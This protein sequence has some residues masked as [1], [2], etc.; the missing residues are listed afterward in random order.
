M[1]DIPR[2]KSNLSRM[3]DAGA[4]ESDI[5]EYL[6]TEGY[7]SAAE[8]TAASADKGSVPWR[9]AK[10]AVHDVG[11]IATGLY[12]AVSDPVGTAKGIYKLGSGLGSKMENY[13]NTFD[14][15]T[16]ALPPE[17]TTER[18]TRDKREEL[19]TALINEKAEAY[20]SWD[21]AM[22]T[23]IDR[24]L[25]TMLDI[26]SVINPLGAGVTRVSP[27]ANAGTIAKKTRDAAGFVTAGGA[28][29]LSGRNPMT[30]VESYKAGARGGEPYATLV[31]NR[32]QSIPQDTV[33]ADMKT[34]RDTV[35]DIRNAEY[36][37]GIKGT[38]EDGRPID[39]SPI[40]T[41]AD[42]LIPSLYGPGGMP[43][44]YNP[45][46]R[47]KASDTAI[48]AAKQVQEE[49]G[50]YGGPRLGPDGSLVGLNLETPMQL[51]ALKQRLQGIAGEHVMNPEASR[52]PTAAADKVR[53]TIIAQSPS[54]EKVMD[55][56]GGTS[57][58][59]TDI[60]A[61]LGLGNRTSVDTALRKAGAV[62][63]RDAS[64]GTRTQNAK[65]LAAMGPAGERIMPA[66]AGQATNQILPDNF[67]KLAATMLLGG[68]AYA[69]NPW[70]LALAP[71][72]SPLVSGA[73]AGY[74]GRAVGGAR[75]AGD[76]VGLTGQR[77]TIA[78]DAITQAG[79]VKA[80]E[81]Y[82]EKR[83]GGR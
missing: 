13:H 50:R 1:A 12:N 64:S 43:D 28:G 23:A 83:A 52:I 11:E 47:P 32:T 14:R 68:G 5:D 45:K 65:E 36:Q 4:P 21:K 80:L 15:I 72:A 2:I 33:I 16:G 82:N 42:E 59:L 48:N 27:L 34:A 53:Q 58:L 19:A 24:P 81:D 17:T 31:G 78:A 26:S 18:A 40:I 10:G 3:I 66:L 55:A 61:S 7:K 70:L 35:K 9:I 71:F 76:A 8:W 54:Y 77:A 75:K 37:A 60:D 56:Y 30:Y 22:N 49:I 29:L 39:V 69:T 57:N 41:H 74:Y 51:D 20:G 67:A 6:S 25:S 44:M 46:G 79:L 62:M 38:A 73:T 63:R